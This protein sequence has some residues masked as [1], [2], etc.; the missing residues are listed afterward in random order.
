MKNPLVIA[1]IDIWE[2]VKNKILPTPS[3]FHYIFSIREL[4]RVFQGICVVVDKPRYG[5]IQECSNI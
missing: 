1:T 2:E 4:A 5:V 3:K